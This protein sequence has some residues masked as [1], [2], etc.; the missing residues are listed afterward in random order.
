MK[1]QAL[2]CL[3]LLRARQQVCNRPD[4]AWNERAQRIS[5]NEFYSTFLAQDW[6]EMVSYTL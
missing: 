3:D 4:V 5:P 2:V 6:S 1:T